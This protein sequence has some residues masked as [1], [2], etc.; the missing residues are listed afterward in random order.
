MSRMRGALLA[1]L[2]ASFSATAA[3][4]QDGVLK[5]KV[6][7]PTSWR[8]YHSR[9][10]CYTI[11]LPF[12]GAELDTTDPASVRVRITRARDPVTYRD[13]AVSWVFVVTATPNPAGLKPDRWLE[14]GSGA[15]DASAGIP[16]VVEILKRRNL[17]LAGR[18][19]SFKQVEGAGQRMDAYFVA[20]GGSMYGVSHTALDFEHQALLKSHR[21]TF[22][23]L[24]DSFEI[25]DPSICRVAGAGP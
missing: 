17:P 11:K 12:S 21:P 13:V 18:T 8:T 19:A 6:L 9:A 22:E 25:E 7:W 2:L 20:H 10:Y 1:A 16:K 14:P 4:A 24:L 15:P 3:L 23:W 5:P